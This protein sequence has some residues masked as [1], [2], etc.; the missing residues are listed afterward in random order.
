[1]YWIWFVVIALTAYHAWCFHSGRIRFTA[2]DG[3]TRR[4]RWV[5]KDENPILYWVLW[6]SGTAFTFVFT[7]V[8]LISI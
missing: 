8:Y 4:T 7:V 1:M 5:Y 3:V 2:G 6:V